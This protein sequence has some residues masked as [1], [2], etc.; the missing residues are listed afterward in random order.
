[1]TYTQTTADD[2]ASASQRDIPYRQAPYEVTFSGDS[3]IHFR[4]PQDVKVMSVENKTDKALIFNVSKYNG[5][6]SDPG[7]LVTD[8]T[9][10]YVE[11]VAVNGVRPIAQQLEFNEGW[12]GTSDASNAT[13]TVYL[14]LGS[15]RDNGLATP[16]TR[17]VG[18]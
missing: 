11:N 1:M 18:A 10:A 15:G 14:R 2:T 17:E 9:S 4:L 7:D 13:G 16:A 8:N 5:I 3:L 6:A 12:I